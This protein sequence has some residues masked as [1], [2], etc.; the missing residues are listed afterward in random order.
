MEMVNTAVVTS[1]AAATAA[2]GRTLDSI[3]FRTGFQQVIN[4]QLH[5]YEHDMGNCQV[6]E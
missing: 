1:Q 4:Q 3:S 2:L 6:S 5:I